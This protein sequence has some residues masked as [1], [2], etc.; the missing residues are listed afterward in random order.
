MYGIVA[1]C[2]CSGEL[3]TLPCSIESGGRLD[4]WKIPTIGKSIIVGEIFAPRG[5]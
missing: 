3:Y 4:R 1:E 5:L 2:G